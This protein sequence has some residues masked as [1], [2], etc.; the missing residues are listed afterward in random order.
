MA[1]RS[2]AEVHGGARGQI[3]GREKTIDCP[4][5]VIAAAAGFFQQRLVSLLGPACVTRRTWM[6]RISSFFVANHK[7]VP[8]RPEG[9][10]D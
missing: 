9:G 1:G 8:A 6:A 4:L 10:I 3:L 7:P 2:G 5:V